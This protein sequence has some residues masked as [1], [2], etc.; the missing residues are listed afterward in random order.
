M[1]GFFPGGVL[2]GWLFFRVTF[3][4]VAFFLIP[5]LTKWNH[6]KFLIIIFS[7]FGYRTKATSRERIEKKNKKNKTKL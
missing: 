5:K 1:G 4:Q 7:V 3:F 6:R 2:L